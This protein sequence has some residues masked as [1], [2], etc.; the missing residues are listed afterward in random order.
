[1]KLRLSLV[2]PLFNE[3]STVPLLVREL[4]A[5][6]K[7]LPKPTEII[8]V[9]DGSKD[10][11]VQ[12][13]QKSRLKYK[14][15]I[16][17]LSRNFGHQAALYA[18]MEEATG[19][20]VVTLDGDLQ[21][22]PALIPEM[23]RL[24]KS[25]YDIVLTKRVDNKFVPKYKQITAKFFYTLMNRMSNTVLPMNS[26]DF[27]SMNQRA[28]RALL[29]IPEHRKFLRGMV[30]W[31]GFRSIIVP[32]EVGER[33]AGKS[34]YSWM[35]MFQLAFY[36]ITSFSVFPLYFAS[37]FSVGLFSL[38]F[39]YALYVLYI[40]FVIGDVVSGWASVLFVLLTLGGCISLFLGIIG[41]Y[42]AAIYD[43]VKQRPVY[44]IKEKKYH[45]GK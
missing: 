15:K 4:N 24:H 35:K 2:I 27:R 29:S 31:I 28:L 43:E 8:F 21:H 7:K 17:E 41:F 13:L 19:Q 36:G 9:D 32:F 37:I 38:A 3:E 23:L 25:G 6:A 10:R 20:Y 40:K 14:K 11:T 26:S 12:K 30:S 22:P 44:I 45:S 39:L 42:V 16:I 1:M 5:I 34:K 33:V 18:G